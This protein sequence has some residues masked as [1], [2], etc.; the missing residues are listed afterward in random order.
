MNVF[1]KSHM[2]K[3]F[4]FSIGIFCCLEVVTNIFL[5]SPWGG[6]VSASC[7]WDCS[8]YLD[9]AQ[10][11]YSI[12]PRVTNL[13]S[14]GIGENRLDVRASQIGMAN[15]AFFPLY[16]ALTALF[17]YLFKINIALIA[18][19]I[20][21]VLWPMVIWLCGRD[22]HERGLNF[23]PILFPLAF[24]LY[25]LNIWYTAQ[26]SEALYGVL[27]M[28]CILMLRKQ[29]VGKAALCCGFLALSRPTG[30]VISVIL[31]LWWG[32]QQH[33]SEKPLREI[34][35]ESLLIIVSS[36]AGLSFYVLYLYYLMGDGFA[37]MHIEVAW[38]RHF[39]VFLFSIFHGFT[40]IK[41]LT[42]S[43][44]AIFG[45]IVIW[46]MVR[47]KMW[48]LNALLLGITGI[49]AL[50]TGITSIGR[51]VVSNPLMIEFLTYKLISYP[52][53][54]RFPSLLILAIL[55]IL[56]IIFWFRGNPILM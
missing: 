19:V 25:P 7:R 2:K 56:T 35:K 34:L 43:L 53:I 6:I 45:S 36:G 16:P 48:R 14:L 51:Y 23:N 13:P 9:I 31:A 28:L 18:L 21:I 1:L 10:N 50:S 49:L 39:R 33:L 27:L 5:A 22:L 42:D 41:H 46:I 30:F 37:F 26:Y 8:W 55:H 12:S 17:A 24:V 4:I 40:H 32:Y 44:F 54:I 3:L 52:L 29:E 15:W 20:N 47:N 38:N 11:G